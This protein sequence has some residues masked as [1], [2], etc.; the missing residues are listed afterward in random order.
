[1]QGL[2]DGYFVLPYTIGDYLSD[3]ISTGKIST[4]LKNLRK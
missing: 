3:D 1:M 4:E 2:A